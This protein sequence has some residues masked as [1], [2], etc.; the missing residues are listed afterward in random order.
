MRKSFLRTVLS[1]CLMLAI[2]CGAGAAV[3]EAKQLPS[4]IPQWDPANY[5]VCPVEGYYGADV[6]V[7]EGV[8]RAF[9]LYYAQYRR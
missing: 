4:E 7:T 3:A 2:A 5:Y 9:N 6:T 1:A 8:T